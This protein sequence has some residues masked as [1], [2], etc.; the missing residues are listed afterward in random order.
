MNSHHLHPT[1]TSSAQSCARF[2]SFMA[3]A[4]SEMSA[5]L[6]MEEHTWWLR[7]T[8]QSSTRLNYARN[9]QLMVTALMVWDASSF[10]I[11]LN[12]INHRF[13]RHR[14]S[15]I[16]I[17]IINNARLHQWTQWLLNS[18][19]PCQLRKLSKLPLPMKK[20]SSSLRLFNQLQLL[21]H[22]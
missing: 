19:Q 16:N 15:S 10:T 9:T 12:R 14:K 13:K 1:F 11:C 21:K 22:Q 4:N 5:P 2:T 8:C 6:L 20:L 18:S 17:N 7:L 3:S